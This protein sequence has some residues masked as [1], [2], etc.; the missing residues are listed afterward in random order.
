MSSQ[1]SS[2][3]IESD[4]D[5]SSICQN[6]QNPQDQTDEIHN[7]TL[8]NSDDDEDEGFCPF[9]DSSISDE[10]KSNR[11]SSS[12]YPR[13]TKN[14]YEDDSSPIDEDWDAECQL[15]E[16]Y[17]YPSYIRR[18]Q[19]PFHWRWTPP[20]GLRRSCTQELHRNMGFE[21]TGL[22]DDL[23]CSSS[24]HFCSFQSNFL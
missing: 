1:S 14:P 24:V 17:Y 11:N 16:P 22:Y 15:I 6:D 4:T 21:P 19:W 9:D 7:K 8:T 13:S 3:G 10:L 2:S 12:H 18:A 23:K 20:L 5:S